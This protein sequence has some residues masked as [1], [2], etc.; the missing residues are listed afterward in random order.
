MGERK[1]LSKKLRFE[2]FKRDKFTCQYCGRSAPDVV[3]QVDH[4]TPV[5]HDGDNDIL[6]LITSCVACNAGKGARELSDDTAIIK[7]K[8]QLNDLQERREQIEMMLEWQQELTSLDSEVTE[9][10]AELWETL[11]A[12]YH[13]TES[14]KASLLDLVRKYSVAEIGDAMRAVAAQKLV[15]EDG[16]YTADSVREAWEYLHR[17][18][19]F[20]RRNADKPYIRDLFY[21]RGIICNRFSYVNELEA[22][23][24]LKSGY[25]AGLE[26][27]ELKD[28]ATTARNWTDWRYQM[29]RAIEGAQ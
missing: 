28:I 24:L 15:M 16:E 29:E 9:G 17:I 26:I 20:Q 5:A 8:Q 19:S 22:L 4:I 3:L 21:V 14:G 23:N 27:E 13:L 2:V 7:R 18:C 12:S 1:S 10:L 25:R 6:N 11:V